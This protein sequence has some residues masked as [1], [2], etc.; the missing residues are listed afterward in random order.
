MRTHAG[1]VKSILLLLFKQD[2]QVFKER[3]A[4]LGDVNVGRKRRCSGSER[5]AVGSAQD[6]E[7][8]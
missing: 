7:Y 6:S 5:M 2:P 8:K 3:C 1:T 4:V